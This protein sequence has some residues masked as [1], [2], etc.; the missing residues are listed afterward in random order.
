MKGEGSK[1]LFF[2]LHMTGNSETLDDLSQRSRSRL[3]FFSR[4]KQWWKQAAEGSAKDEDKEE[5]SDD[6][7]LSVGKIATKRPRRPQSL[8]SINR[9]QYGEVRKPIEAA[10][11]LG[12]LNTLDAGRGQEVSGK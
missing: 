10:K 7:I 12:R 5:D 1:I 3:S 6:D 8:D 2:E 4:I 9:R 11:T